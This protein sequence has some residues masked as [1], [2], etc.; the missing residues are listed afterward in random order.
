[1]IVGIDVTHPAP[2]NME[3]TPSIAAVVASTDA[4]YAQWPGS[5]RCQES[6]KEIVTSLQE[7]MEER[8]QYWL[9][10]NKQMCPRRILI[11]RDGK[12]T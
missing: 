11:Y 10:Q 1:M 3:G 8:L 7:M 2:G 6:K 5:I 9:K 4:Q 12:H